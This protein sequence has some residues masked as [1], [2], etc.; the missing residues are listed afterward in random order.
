MVSHF[1]A[2]GLIFLYRVDGKFLPDETS[3]TVAITLPMF[4]VHTTT[5][6]KYLIAHRLDGPRRHARVTMQYAAVSVLLPL[7]FVFSFTTAI[8]FKG[9]G[10]VFSDFNEFATVLGTLQTLFGVYVGMVVTSLFKGN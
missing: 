6:I 8:V 7:L 9:R 5:V 4:A 3:S 2:I 10:I 1:F